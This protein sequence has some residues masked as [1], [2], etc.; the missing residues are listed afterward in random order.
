MTAMDVFAGV[1]FAISM[2]VAYVLGVA[3]E[4]DRRREREQLAADVAERR[5][6]VNLNKRR[7]RAS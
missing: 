1:C 2:R 4:R 3:T 7:G 5:G 6:V